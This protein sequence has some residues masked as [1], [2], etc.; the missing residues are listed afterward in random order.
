METSVINRHLRSLL[1]LNPL[2]GTAVTVDR[3]D[4]SLNPLLQFPN[5]PTQAASLSVK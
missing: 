5:W 2:L 3:M 1:V 4:L